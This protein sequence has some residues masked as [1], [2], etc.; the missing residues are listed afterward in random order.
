MTSWHNNVHKEKEDLS[1]SYLTICTLC[2]YRR[3]IWYTQTFY[4]LYT[5]LP[6]KRM[7]L[8]YIRLQHVSAFHFIYALSMD[9]QTHTQLSSRLHSSS[10]STISDDTTTSCSFI[11]IVCFQKEYP[12]SHTFLQQTTQ[13][14]RIFLVAAA[15]SQT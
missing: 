7:R 15:L 3:P 10:S 14:V 4:H 12:P 5:I 6:I 9:T 8:F 2:V 11:Q 1:H 13:Q